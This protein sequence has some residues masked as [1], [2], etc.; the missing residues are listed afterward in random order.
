MAKYHEHIKYHEDITK[1]HE[2][3]KEEL[4]FLLKLQKEMNT[5][6]D[7]SQAEPRY[8]VIKGSEKLYRVEDD[9][10]G[11]EL[12]DVDGGYSSVATNDKEIFEYIR[13]EIIPDFNSNTEDEEKIK[14]DFE[15]EEIHLENEGE[16]ISGTDDV[17]EWLKDKTCGN[18]E[19]VSYRIVHKIYDNTMFLTQTNAENHLRLNY[20]HY[21]DDAH[22]YAMTSWRSSET[23]MLWKILRQVDWEDVLK[24]RGI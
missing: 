6:D 1:K 15:N 12:L 8:L 2:I 21:S 14:I 4:D 10:D 5:Q 24:K 22:A 3:T 16:Y 9:I 17:V 20:Y 23:E 7:V 13:D 18:Y 11:Y 19:L